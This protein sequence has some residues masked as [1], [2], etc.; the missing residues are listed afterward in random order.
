MGSAIKW[1]KVA[2]SDYSNHLLR[3]KEARLF[4]R[5]NFSNNV[6]SNIIENR[7]E[8]INNGFEFS[9]DFDSRDIEID[10]GIKNTY[11]F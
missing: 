7:L 3:A 9:N 5:E 8:L 10:I 11:G 4:V 6:V 2:K 1:F